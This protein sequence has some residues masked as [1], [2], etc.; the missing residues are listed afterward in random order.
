MDTLSFGAWLRRRRRSLDLTQDELADRVGCSVETVRKL[1]AERLRPSK[2]LAERLAGFLDIPAEQQALFVRFARGQADAE[3]L[4]A[5]LH[6]PSA[7]TPLPTLAP[8]LPSASAHH[9]PRPW[10]DQRDTTQRI[11][12]CTS[13]DGVRLAYATVGQGPVFVK[14][15]NWLSHI[16][17][18]WNSP[19]WRHWMT[20]L[21]QHHTL[22][23]YDERGCG[24][25]D[26]NVTDFSLDAWVQDLELVVDALDIDRFP[27]LGISQG[28][29]VALAYAVRHPERVSHLILY[30]TYARG[31]LTRSPTPDQV[32]ETE[33]LINL[34]RFGWGKDNPAFRQVF[35]S[36]FMPEATFEQMHWFNDLQRVSTSPE[37][38]VKF[39]IAF[40]QLDVQALATQVTTPT[41]VLH[42]QRDAVVPFEE[43]RRLA[44]LV[45]GARFVPLDSQNHILLES[46]PAWPRC[47]AEVHRFLLGGE[48]QT[49]V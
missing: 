24:L 43:G 3:H 18:D 33:T 47:L 34:T 27:L 42:G 36:L 46:E 11:H 2:A 38:A 1:E 44:A 9:V 23:R 20:G 26:W 19:V 45:P 35:T 39:R 6:V 25:S 8:S 41:L 16:E 13:P 5:P 14:A 7:T 48:P 37:N 21:S 10:L 4:P 22:V 29:P 40:S 31:R 12:F 30:G 17:Y 32:T 15:A 49:T 28:G